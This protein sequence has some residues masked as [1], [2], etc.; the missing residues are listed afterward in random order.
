MRVV[1]QKRRQALPLALLSGLTG[2]GA[3]SLSSVG[4]EGQGEAAALGTF[5]ISISK[6]SCHSP[7]MRTRTKVWPGCCLYLLLTAFCLVVIC[8]LGSGPI[9]RL[10]DVGVLPSVVGEIT[11]V[12]ID[13]LR[14]HC[15]PAKA[16][17]DWY[18]YDVCEGGGE[19]MP[20]ARRAENV[21]PF[22]GG[23]TKMAT[24]FRACRQRGRLPSLRGF[25]L[26][27]HPVTLALD[28]DGVGMMQEPVQNGTG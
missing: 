19:V 11:H 2:R 26:I 27:F 9:L 23:D 8:F 12:P 22:S 4:G 24:G 6:H 5:W 18:I 25:D 28:N 17:F 10:V 3:V 14:N 1:A 20:P 15:P 7:P 21:G 13:A 16:L